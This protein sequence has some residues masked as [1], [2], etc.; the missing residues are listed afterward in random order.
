MSDLSAWLSSR[1]ASSDRDRFAV[2]PPAH[3][4]SSELQAPVASD[5]AMLQER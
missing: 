4:G 3:T 2:R 5:R 1:D